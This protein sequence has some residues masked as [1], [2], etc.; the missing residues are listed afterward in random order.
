VVSDVDGGGTQLNVIYRDRNNHARQLYRVAGESAWRNADLTDRT[1][2]PRPGDNANLAAVVSDVDGGGTQLNVIYRD[3]N[4]QVRQLYRVAGESAWR[5]ADLTDRTGAPRPGDNAN[6]AAV[7]SDV[8]GGGTQLNVIYRDRN[9]HVRQ[10][11]RVAGE[12]AW[13]NADLTS[14]A[15]APRPGDNAN[16]TAVVSPL[17]SGATP[18]VG[19]GTQLNVIYRDRNIHVGQLY[20]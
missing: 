2:A 10:L 15:G 18:L 13:R 4:N 8:D 5:N 6:L 19:G 9:N 20:R 1:G 17:D 3:R 11:Y 12:S 14:L 7:V 16:P